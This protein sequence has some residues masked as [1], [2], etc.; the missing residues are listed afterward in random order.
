MSAKRQQRTLTRRERRRL[1]ARQQQRQPAARKPE[2]ARLAPMSQSTPATIN[3]R[4]DSLPVPGWHDL[5]DIQRA[6]PSTSTQFTPSDLYPS[7]EAFQRDFR[8]L[9][10]VSA[11][12]ALFEETDSTVEYAPWVGELVRRMSDDS[13][14]PQLVD[15]RIQTILL[16][17][18]LQKLEHYYDSKD[19]LP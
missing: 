4:E 1:R 7:N 3:A 5:D 6:S 10:A 12:R 9:L 2:Q 17:F 11:G 18:A 16:V 15:Q 8:L 19:P 13:I 14:D